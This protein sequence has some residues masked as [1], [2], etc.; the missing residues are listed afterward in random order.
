MIKFYFNR[1]GKEDHDDGDADDEDD[2]Y[3][4]VFFADND[5][6]DV[7]PLIDLMIYLWAKEEGEKEKKEEKEKKVEDNDKEE[8]ENQ[9][10]V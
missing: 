7:F 5:G 6:D 10:D 2:D 9:Q 1:L 8:G 3:D 4:A